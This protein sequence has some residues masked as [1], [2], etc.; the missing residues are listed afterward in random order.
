M[1]KNPGDYTFSA[2]RRRGDVLV[3][4]GTVLAPPGSE[5]YLIRDFDNRPKTRAFRLAFR[6]NNAVVPFVPH[7]LEHIEPGIPDSVD[8]LVIH[9]P[10]GNRYFIGSSRRD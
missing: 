3:I 10:S 1:P 7:S 5:P 9:L 2:F 4:R 6:N 8:S